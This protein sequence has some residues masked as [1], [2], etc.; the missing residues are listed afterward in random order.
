[1]TRKN[2]ILQYILSVVAIFFSLKCGM[3]VYQR[4]EAYL[5]KGQIVPSF[6]L[7]SGILIFGFLFI[8]I[9]IW[10]PDWLAPIHRLLNKIPVVKWIVAVFILAVPCILYVF[11]H[12]SQPYQNVWIRAFL[13]LL[14]MSASAWL[15]SKEGR[16]TFS[17]FI[18]SACILA[19]FAAVLNEFHDVSGYPFSIGWSE[20]NRM[21]DYSVLFGRK[22]YNFPADQTIPAYIDIGR[23]SLWGAVFLLPHVSIVLMRL[24]NAF[25]FSIPYALLGWALFRKT[26][27]IS[28]GAWFLVGLWSMLFLIQGPIYTPLVLVA[29]LI[30][31]GRKSPFWLNCLLTFIAGIYAVMSRSTWVAAPAVYAALLAFIEIPLSGKRAGPQRW[32]RAL[33]LGIS[34]FLGAGCY[35][36]RNTI[37]NF[38]GKNVPSAAVSA[39]ASDSGVAA[40]TVPPL[41]SPA[42]FQY[43][44]SRQSFIWSRL[45]P[46][47]TY[48]IGIIW[49]LCIAVLPLVVLL[50]IWRVRHPS[51]LDF[52]QKLAVFLFLFIF[53]CVGILVSVK[54]GGGSNL[55]NLDM[56][57]ICLL[58]V[59]ALAWED[60]FGNW[61]CEKISSGSWISLLVLMAVLL[62]VSQT[63]LNVVPRDYPPVTETA[64]ALEKVQNTVRKNA[65]KKILF[66]D[67]RQLLTFGYVEKI[68]LI[69]DYEKK[70]MMDEAMANNAAFFAPYIKD[71]KAHRF[72]II[73]S[74]PLRIK[75]Q[76][77]GL[78]FS[79]ENDFFVKWVSVP[80]LCY[81]QPLET[82]EDQG[83]QILV[84]RTDPLDAEGVF[85]P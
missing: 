50:L 70:W 3:A 67:Q 61:L 8:L 1:M 18:P 44:F 34:G 25:L 30:A 52:W 14:A 40:E 72:D 24:W 56:F 78:D 11:L 20:G 19:A 27:G 84:P 81:Y 49:A 15:I 66:M 42:W 82:F 80:T 33:S 36:M 7:I 2:R 31:L 53:L 76:G 41:L 71:L 68:P 17:S 58:L 65:D 57:L 83:V 77:S 60:G 85:C 74:E 63:A 12:A 75:F 45:W 23:Q 48:H 37:F 69:A 21:W 47:E 46:N 35:L 62:P 43:S 59:A 9:L 5:T 29:I 16:V 10:V 55:H 32:C 38:F 64:D 4:F 79:E 54:I 13:Y 51:K 26:E 39:A 22:L 73:I 28:R 6:L